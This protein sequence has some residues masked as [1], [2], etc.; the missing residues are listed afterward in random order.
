MFGKCR[1]DVLAHQG[2]KD[3]DDAYPG[4]FV[5]ARC[6]SHAGDYNG[7]AQRACIGRRLLGRRR[8]LFASLAETL[9]AD[10]SNDFGT[11]RNMPAAR[12]G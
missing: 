1:A 2:S 12:H 11:Q 4:L 3:S 6:R 7:A 10:V 8:R 9:L 5:R